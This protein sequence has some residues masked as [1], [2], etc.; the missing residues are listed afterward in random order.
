MRACYQEP[1]KRRTSRY[2]FGTYIC[3]G[4]P[5]GGSL[6]I[7]GE[8]FFPKCPKRAFEI[9]RSSSFPFFFSFNILIQ[10]LNDV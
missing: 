3:S 9:L 7:T 4:L 5:F 10:S 2:V 1:L 6:G 8:R